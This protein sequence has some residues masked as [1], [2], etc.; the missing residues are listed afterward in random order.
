MLLARELF[1]DT[2]YEKI[3]W[4]ENYRWIICRVLEYGTMED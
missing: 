2:N 1:W 3:N 4:K